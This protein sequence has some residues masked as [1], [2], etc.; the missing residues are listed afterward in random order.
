MPRKRSASSVVF[1]GACP[2]SPPFI[3][4]HTPLMG[5]AYFLSLFFASV[6]CNFRNCTMIAF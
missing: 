5:A 2:A 6:T 1:W 4:R 3:D